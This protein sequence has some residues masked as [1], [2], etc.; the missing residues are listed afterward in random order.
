MAD[1][2]SAGPLFGVV[3]WSPD[4][5]WFTFSQDSDNQLSRI[6]LYSVE[7]GVATPLTTDRYDN[8][9]ATLLETYG[10]ASISD[11]VRLE[12]SGGTLTVKINGSV[13]SPTHSDSTYTGGVAGIYGYDNGS[14]WD[15]LEFG[16]VGGGG[17]PTCNRGGLMGLG[18]GC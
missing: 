3:R 7:T 13:Q 10:A 18:A 15:N 5:R 6:L 12:R 4:S 8:G 11:L 17:G 14:R 1:S 16:L 2:H 9:S